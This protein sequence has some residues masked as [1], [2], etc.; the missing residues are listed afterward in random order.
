MA[1]ILFVGN[2]ESEWQTSWQRCDILKR[3]GHE[4]IPFDQSR[5]IDLRQRRLLR[6]LDGQAFRARNRK[7]FQRR[8][9]EE[10][11][12]HKPEII[13]MEKALLAE[14][15][16]LEE[17]RSGLNSV[18]LVAFQEDNPF[19]ERAYESPF[20]Q[21]FIDAIPAYDLHFVKRPDDVELFTL[22]GARKAAIFVTG[23]YE[24]LYGQAR[25][26]PVNEFL[27]PVCFVGT[28]IDD[29]PKVVSE[30][31]RRRKID[32]HVYGLRWHYH[33]ITFLAPTHFHGQLPASRHKAVICRS[34]VNLGLVSSSN[35]DQYNG[36]SFDITA[37]GGFLLAARTPAHKEFY[38]EGIEA[39]FFSDI[40]EMV[41]KIRFYL[42]NED[43]RQRIARNGHA[44]AMD[45]DY[46]L[47]RRMR[48]ALRV[49]EGL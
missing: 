30:L 21:T 27:H 28:A 12:K 23:F 17:L 3:L 20:W 13:W 6:R 2:L 46:S 36:R 37:S 18:R 35:R 45:S 44:R 8:L 15:A 4:V 43:I 16:T 10:A 29:R 39:D 40:G 19:G 14:K 22:R 33:L 41:D 26:D 25:F 34:K 5:L 49:V 24:P 32:I 1:K 38:K 7:E 48:E 9:I 47:S 11:G 42:E 31:I